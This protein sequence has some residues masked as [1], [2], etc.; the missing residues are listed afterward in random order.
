[1][2]K[3]F[4]Q[5]KIL[6]RVI[7]LASCCCLIAACGKKAPPSPPRQAEKPVIKDLS[8]HIQGNRLTLTW[9]ISEQSD[10]REAG[11]AG[12]SV[13]KSK[14]KVSEPECSNCPLLFERIA[15]ISIRKTGSHITGGR[16]TNFYDTLEKGYHYRY[17]VTTNSVGGSTGKDSNTIVFQY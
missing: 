5:R 17:K 10:L 1:M 9:T 7:L 12:F 14:R 11:V 13:F 4:E 15:V 16:V 2:F 6:S 3:L 8:R